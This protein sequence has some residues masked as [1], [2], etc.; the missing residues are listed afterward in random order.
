MGGLGGDS[1]PDPLTGQETKHMRRKSRE[2]FLPA[3]QGARKSRFLGVLDYFLLPISNFR[4]V[5]VPR[6]HKDRHARKYTFVS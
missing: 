2:A 1:H 6:L 5:S 4:P 3:H